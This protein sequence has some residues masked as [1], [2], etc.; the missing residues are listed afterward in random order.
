[1]FN[2]LEIL[3]KKYIKN[4]ETFSQC[5][6]QQ[7]QEEKILKKSSISDIW[8]KKW[9]PS[10]KVFDGSKEKKCVLKVCSEVLN[11]IVVDCVSSYSLIAYSALKCFNSMQS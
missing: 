7:S 1:M 2:I 5:S 6:T 8:R 9:N 4:K 3:L 10:Q 11:K